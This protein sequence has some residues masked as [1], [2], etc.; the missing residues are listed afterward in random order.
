MKSLKFISLL[1]IFSC[2]G[3]GASDGTSSS[4]SGNLINN[5]I[6]SY[7]PPIGTSTD[8]CVARSSSSNWSENFNETVLDT[9]KW[10]FDEGCNNNG[11]GCNGNNELQN[12]TRNDSDNLFI[13]NGMLKIQPIYEQNIGSDNIPQDYTSAKIMTKDKF[14]IGSNSRITVCFK[15]P[16]GTGLWPAIW[17]LPY[18]GS[19]WPSGGEIDLIEAKGRS[20]PD[21]GSPAQNNIVSSAVHFGTEWPDHKY[22]V[23]E[24]YSSIENTFQD[25]FHSMTLIFQ[26][27]KIDFYIDNATNPHLSIN[28][29]IFPLNQYNYPFNRDYYLILNVAVG[30]NFD[31]GRIESSEI[32]SD[33]MCSN[34]S[35]NP[36]KKRLLIDWIEY[37]VLN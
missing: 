31:A 23:G 33:S 32:C 9:S 3:G 1:F 24:S 7:S 13:D 8:N 16:E 37:E 4:D 14:A 34:F 22:I 30:G 17:M 5:G 35:D 11:G 15:L 36:D 25:Y 20:Y 6:Y 19:L 21:Q 18:D 27:N 26:E 10:S 29:S 2:G 12:Y 28:P